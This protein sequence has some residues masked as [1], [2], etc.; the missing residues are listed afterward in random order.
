MRQ[1]R[2]AAVSLAL[3]YLALLAAAVGHT[4]GLY[5]DGQKDPATGTVYN[6]YYTGKLPTIAGNV[7]AAC[8]R[9]NA[10]LGAPLP[11]SAQAADQSLYPT[12]VPGHG[13]YAP[14][15]GVGY[16][17]PITQFSKGEYVNASESQDDYAVMLGHMPYVPDDY[18][19]STATAATLQSGKLQPCCCRCSRRHCYRLQ[20]GRLLLDRPPAARL[21][22]GALCA[23]AHGCPCHRPS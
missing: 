17:K 3:T 18:G 12:A 20:C 4:V 19:N 15:M 8:C 5:H 11:A 13:D 7:S 1:L 21:R 22:L 23:R 14:I 2:C 10:A 9:S 16:Y 6:G